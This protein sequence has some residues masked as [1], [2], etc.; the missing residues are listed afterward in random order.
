MKHVE[1]VEPLLELE[2]EAPAINPRFRAPS[3]WAG[4]GEIQFINYSTRYRS[5]LKPVLR[6]LT[7]KILA[8][9]KIGIIG[10]TGAGKSSFALALLRGLEA[11]SGK[12]IIDGLDINQLGLRDLR[13]SIAFVPQ[14]P[15][16]FTGTIRTTLDPFGLSTDEEILTVLQRVHLIDSTM[17]EPSYSNEKS[18]RS[19][20]AW[21]VPNRIDSDGLESSRGHAFE[22]EYKN[23][24]MFNLS[25][26]VA[27]SGSNISHGQRQLLCL[28]RVLLRDPRILIMD[29]ATASIDLVTD[30]KIQSTIRELTQTTIIT[31]AHR[32]QTIIDYDRILVLDDGRVVEFDAPWELLKKESGAFRGMCEKS[33][34]LNGLVHAARQAEAQKKHV[35]P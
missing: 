30:A 28:A 29:E 32:L 4:E 17:N 14:D 22:K 31:I 11:E 13:R 25:A 6:N 12:V 19:P 3:N 1:R 10:R 24:N 16:L 5:D 34:N 21:Q 27:P 18:L 15:S 33:G 35:S 9:E 2:Q 26:P 7:L 8:R 23:I 20:T